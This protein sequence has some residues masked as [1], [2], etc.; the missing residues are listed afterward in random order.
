MGRKNKT[1]ELLERE[2]SEEVLIQFLAEIK[3]L[4]REVKPVLLRVIPLEKLNR[5]RVSA[6]S[7][8]NT[9]I[10][11]E[12][13]DTVGDESYAALVKIFNGKRLYISP[14]YFES[15]NLKTQIMKD[16]GKGMQSKELAEKYGYS[17]SQINRIKR[18]QTD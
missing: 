8:V 13:R 12:L 15:M 14:A 18:S 16:A 5:R 2:I 3:C 17:I 7:P 9:H 11:L 4:L 1:M 10:C 6:G